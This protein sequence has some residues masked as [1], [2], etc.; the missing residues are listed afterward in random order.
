MS[1]PKPG[2]RFLDKDDP[3]GPRV[4][5][6]LGDHGSGPWWQDAQDGTKFCCDWLD[7]YLWARFQ[8]TPT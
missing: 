8:E 3:R 5:I 4:V 7:Y 6:Y 1:E 2:Q